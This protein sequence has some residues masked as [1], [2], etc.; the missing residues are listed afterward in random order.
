MSPD[1][2]EK[3]LD[4]AVRL[5]ASD[6]TNPAERDMSVRQLQAA[7]GIDPKLVL[8]MLASVRGNGVSEADIEK[9]KRE[10][11]SAQSKFDGLVNATKTLRTSLT[12]IGAIAKD[13]RLP[14]TVEQWEEAVGRVVER[15]TRSITAR[16]ERLQRQQEELEARRREVLSQIEVAQSL[17]QANVPSLGGPTNNLMQQIGSEVTGLFQQEIA[18]MVAGAA[19]DVQALLLKRFATLTDQTAANIARAKGTI[20]EMPIGFGHAESYEIGQTVAGKG[21]YAGVW[22]P[23]DR[24]GRSLGKKYNIFAAPEDL[25]DSS[26]TKV[27]LTFK[28]A[29]KEVG[30]L[31]NWHNYNGLVVPDRAIDAGY[32]A[33]LYET[34]KGNKYKGE[35]VIPTRDVLHGKDIDGNDVQEDN[36]YNYKDIGDFAG[37][38]TT[39]TS[40]SGHALWYWSSTEH[41]DFPDYVYN[42]RFS[43]GDD[44]WDT[45]DYYR[46]SS[47]PVRFEELII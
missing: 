34:L 41:R 29:A 17:F 16:E 22:E 33:Y 38:Y 37:T 12:K 42:V 44:G 19:E 11:E 25:V 40:R 39:D 46:L 31:K 26:G 36:L 27:L 10:A 8:D 14:E 47:R 35:W 28:N 1:R 6:T 2:R 9:L 4:R 13:D 5:V 43:D 32:E 23:K 45:K 30:K 24:N 18:K 15:Q 3:I 7:L 20:A 21:I